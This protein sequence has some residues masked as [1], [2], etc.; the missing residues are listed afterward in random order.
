MSVTI[1]PIFRPSGSNGVPSGSVVLGVPTYFDIS[2]YSSVQVHALAQNG[3]AGTASVS[4]ASVPSFAGGVPN[5]P[6]PYTPFSTLLTLAVPTSINGTNAP[7]TSS[8]TSICA[9]YMSVSFSATSGSTS[10]TTGSAFIT[11]TLR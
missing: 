3:I 5:S 4:V 6:T 9:K 2:P 11:L 1:T 8:I 10:S 7:T